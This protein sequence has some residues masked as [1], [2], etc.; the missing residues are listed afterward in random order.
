MKEQAAPHRPLNALIEQPLTVSD[1]IRS[2]NASFPRIIF[3][4]LS[5]LTWRHRYSSLRRQ[6]STYSQVHSEKILSRCSSPRPSSIHT[7]N[8][9]PTNLV[10]AF[11]SWFRACRTLSAS[12][13][14]RRA[15]FDRLLAFS[16][17]QT[18]E[19]WFVEAK[20]AQQAAIRLYDELRDEER[21]WLEEKGVCSFEWMVVRHGAGTDNMLARW[22][23][24]S[25]ALKEIM[26]E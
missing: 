18:A 16:A 21:E 20:E 24:L 15:E 2:P 10:T 3:A 23:V 8:S 22:K 4:S 11:I 26:Q 7:T 14:A 25:D 9:T 13:R 5:E 17:E 1:G 12:A 6:A 19:G